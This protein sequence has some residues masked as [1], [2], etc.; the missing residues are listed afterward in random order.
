MLRTPDVTWPLNESQ[1]GIW[2]TQESDPRSPMLN[3]GEYY[4]IPGPV[5]AEVLDRAVGLVVAENDILRMRFLSTESGPRQYPDQEITHPLTVVDVSADTDPKAAALAIMHED[6]AT[7]LDMVE[8]T[9]YAHTLFRLGNDRHIWYQRAHHL[10]VDGYTFM[11]LAR[12]VAEVYTALLGGTDTGRPYGS[13]SALLDEA[14]RYETGEEREEDARYWTDYLAG[15]P[16]HTALTPHREDPRSHYLRSTRLMDEE[17]VSRIERAAQRAGTGW[18]Q[19]L[20]A[21][22]AAYTHRWTGERDILLSL[23]VAARTTDLSRRTPGMSSNVVPLR[24][25]VTPATSLADLAG[26]VAT[27]LRSCLP[28]QRHPAAATR[29]LLGQTPQ[30]R[31]EF[32]PLVNIMSFDYGL[33]FGGVPSV[34]HNIF[35]GP[36]EELRIDVLQRSRG[37]PL[38]IDFDANPAVFSPEELERHADSFLRLLDALCEDPGVPVGDL[39]LLTEEERGRVLEEFSGAAVRSDADRVVHEV[40][41]ER[42]AGSPDAVALVF[43]EERLTYGEVN[44]RAN[45]LARHLRSRGLVTGAAAGVLLERGVEF[46]VALLAVLKAGAA[47]VPLDPSFPDDRLDSMMSAAGVDLVVTREDMSDRRV[48]TRERVRVDTE[49]ETIAGHRSDGLGLRVDPGDVACVMFTSGS[50][51]TPKGVAAPHRAVVSTLLG[52]DYLDFGPEQVWLQA[53]PVSWDA[54]VLEFWGALLHGSV[55]VLH[56]GQV[57]EPSRIADLVARH[58]V[59]TMWLSAGLFNLLLDECPEVFSGVGQVA[60]GGEAPSVE[61]MRRFLEAFPDVRLQHG[62]GPVE[63]MVFTNSHRVTRIEGGT[64]PV[65]APLVNRRC[66]VLDGR[67]RPVPVGVPGELYVGGEGLAL[68]YVGRPDLTAERFVTDPFHGRGERMYRTGDLVRWTSDG[69]LEFLGRVDD[70]VKIRGFRI[71][72]GEVEAALAALP[73]VGQCAVVV[74]EDRP[75]DKRLVAYTAPSNESGATLDAVA[76]RAALATSLPDYMLPSVVVVLDALPLNANGKLDRRALPAPD[77]GAAATG[78]GPRTPQEEILCGVFRELLG[79]DAVGIDDSFFDLGG[80]SLLLSR[81]IGR[82]RALLGVE[83]NVRDLFRSPTVAAIGAMVGA[84]LPGAVRRPPVAV[85]RPRRVPLSFAQRRLWF[86]NRME[87]PSPTYNIPVVL[88]LRGRVEEDALRSALGDVVARHEALRTVFPSEEGEPYQRILDPEESGPVLE[89]EETTTSEVDRLVHEVVRHAFD[90]EARIPFRA[91]LLRTSEEESVLVVLLHHIAGDGWSMG[92]LMDDLAS[93]YT[94]RV[95]NREPEWNGRP[96]LAIQYAD[97]TLWQNGLMD[98]ED[99]E[100]LAARQLDFWREALDG[101]PEVLD[102]P[103]D[104]PRPTV[105]DHRGETV[106][107]T[108]DADLHRSLSEVA[109]G[110]GVTLFMVF[111]AALAVALSRSGAGEDVPIGTPVA[112]RTDPALDDLVGFFVNTLVLRTDVSGDPSFAELLERVREADLA[113]FDHQDVPFDKVVEALAPARSA[114]HHPLFQVMLVLQNNRE[115]TLELPGLDT[116]L[117]LCSTGASKFD[118]T[119]SL[120]EE[121]DA[122]GPA[123]IT[124]DLEFATDLFDRETAR[125][126]VERWERVLA[127]VA[128]DPRVSVGRIDV[129]SRQER[130]RVL[131]ELPGEGERS[132][133][134]DRA[135]HEVFEERVAQSPDAVALVFG[136][137]RLTYGEVNA[138]ANRLARHLRNRGLRRGDVAGVYLPRGPEM[139]VAVLAVL[140]AGAGY[141]LLDVEFPAERLASVVDAAGVEKVISEGEEG[142]V[143]SRAESVRIDEDRALIAALDTADLG[144]EVSAA[145]VACVMFT[146]GSTGTPKGVMAP[147]RALV[148]TFLGQDYADFGADQVWLQCSPVSWDAFA[149]ELFG[150]LL[151]GGRCVLQPGQRPRFDAIADLVVRHGV[152]DLQMSAGLFNVMLDERPEVFDVVRVAMTAGEA[153]SVAHVAKA[154]AEHPGVRVVNGYGPAE[155]MGFTT[156]HEVRAVEEGQ[157][158]IPIGRPIPGGRTYVLDG[159]MRPVPVGVTGELYVGGEG[160]ALGYVGRPDLTAERFV[161]DPFGTPG[162]RMYRTGDLVRWTSDGVLEYLGRADDQV[163]VRGFRVEPGEVEAALA[164]LPGVGR[165][166]VVVREDR[167][168]DKRLVAYTT[169]AHKDGVVLDAV[170]LRAGLATSLPEYMVPSAV[171]VLEELPLTANGKLDRRALP[172]PDFSVVSSGRGPRDAREEILC[173]LFAEVLGLESVGI[174]DSFFD[175]GGHSLLATKLI[176]RIRAVL[177]AE[178][179]LRA[180]FAS[181]TVVGVAEAVDAAGGGRVRPP[182]VAGERPEVLPLSFAQ[183]RLWFLNRLKGA[184]TSYNVPLVLRLRGRVDEDALRSALGDVVARHEVLRTVFPFSGDEPRQ[185]VFTEEEARERPLLDVHTCPRSQTPRRVDALLE[186]AF[187]LTMDL[188]VRADLLRVSEEES[189]LVV[190][191]HHIATDGWSEGVLLRDLAEAYGARCEGRIPGWEPLP[192][193]YTDYTLWQN[194]LMDEEDPQGLAARQLDFWRETLDG[195][196]QALELPTDRPRPAVASNRGESLAFDLDADLHRSLSEVARGHGVTLFMVFQAALAVALSR[197]GAGEDVPIGTPVAGRTDPALDDLVGFFV[198]T[199]VLRTDVSGDPSFAELLERV[200]EADLA[201]FEHADVPFERVVEAVAP[202]RS[203]GHHPLFQVM[204]VLQNNEAADLSLPGLEVERES[205][206]WKVSKFDLTFSLSERAEGVSGLLEFATDL[207]DRET[208]RALVERW[209]R[210]LAAVA[211]D[212]RVSVGR[213]DVLSRRERRRVLEEFGGAAERSDVDGVVHEV[214]E[215]R[216]AQSPDAVALVF[217]EERLTYGE[218]NARANRLAR[219]LREHG[220][221]PGAMVGVY[222]PRGPEMVVAVLAVLKAGA[223]YTLLDV[224]FPAAR[225]ASVIASAGVGVVVSESGSNGTPALSGV[226]TVLVDSEAGCISGHDEGDL[227]LEVSPES[228]ACVM[229]TSGS[230]GT[231]KGVVTAHRGLVG[232]FVDQDYLDFDADQVWLQ[233]SPV[234]WDAFALEL[235]GAL[236]FGGRCVLQPGQRPRFDA[237]ADLVVRHGVTDLQMSAGLFNVMLDE[238][239]EVFD[240][241]RVAMT[242]GEAASVAHV[243]KALAEHPG[244]RVVNGYGPAENMGFTTTHEVGSIDGGERS[245]P[246]GSPVGGSRVYVLDRWLDPVPTGVPGE[247]YIAGCTLAQ[248]YLR[249]P[250]LTAERF[251]PDPFG[252]PGG[253]MYRTGDLVRWTSGGV[254]EYLGRADDQVKVR[255]FR[256]EPGEVEAA[257]MGLAGV[258][259]AVVV[260]RRDPDDVLSLVGY[261]VPEAGVVLD[262]VVLRA[263]LAT[264][265]PEYMVPSAV[266]VL[267]ELPLTAN[268]KLDRRALPEPDFSVVSSGRGPRDAREEILCGLFAEVLGLESVGIDDSF[269]DLGG[270]SLLATKLIAR[271]HSAMDAKM[272]LEDVFRAPTVAFLAERLETT[273]VAVARPALRRRTRAGVEI[274]G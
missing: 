243:A 10:L 190:L 18:K 207:F 254:L 21:A 213:I 195:S 169:P 189:V 130:R 273:P 174:D 100:G 164:A 12:R 145:D 143:T 115:A 175:L 226:H 203:M 251:V 266:V 155:N 73:G 102:L 116:T 11:L 78:R 237:I 67:M 60:T 202:A 185:R 200:R 148:G 46:A 26:D 224:E 172:E 89:V 178:V 52:Q 177:G 194:G 31:R 95:R 168:G 223:G 13:F 17:D 110:H 187:D 269:F 118:L 5:D 179:E 238:R 3:N 240:V 198:N 256:V 225:V 111:Q 117:E 166:A 87:G 258:A 2:F 79:V 272:T 39:D 210:V 37:G 150:A 98:E 167:P 55:C 159:R 47:Y 61:H 229:F 134:A 160:L 9:L 8:D 156:F 81:L 114:A 151:F 30:S 255:G 180:L 43:G 153:A 161:P 252:T 119:L 56:D 91:W 92:P 246:V 16:H 70:Q 149:L 19:L 162:G 138:R 262:A 96:E 152:T 257:L 112:G 108:L 230:S 133:I 221:E 212:P 74:R 260:P 6:L 265:L 176:A 57:P 101:A 201:A 54:F 183:R 121:I 126:L 107:L 14:K 218:V 217:G 97:Y 64:V 236:L 205:F 104:R 51:G 94:D 181:P 253:R 242:A 247:L 220:V 113:A 214:F 80:H 215:E 193:Q 72:P 170:V 191:M 209:E 77:Y 99:P 146:S 124:G 147:H 140:K 199:L 131:E 71:E 234:S 135:V 40:F 233:C 171:V 93:A 216:V 250:D 192:I 122:S 120:S 204:L 184:S 127:A 157:V 76:L 33:D 239:P 270:H 50:T 219:H 20:M 227:G 63:S 25:D 188:P 136:E 69:V 68:G 208:A 106:P 245:V 62:Y 82:V 264:S 154:L 141:T 103:L 182:V 7:P 241:V 22:V 84:A 32:G 261:V 186:R 4:E 165:C 128:A 263:G 211:A 249:R 132:G 65:G 125:A 137:E 15:A 90:I 49:A 53:A 222:L 38:H 36:I 42:A 142:P 28:H 274:G 29:R 139:V 123:G 231:P 34:P 244:V 197:S 105:A 163:K 144:I 129:L 196:P 35:Q 268:G 228:V 88:R 173:G 83:L 27:A 59:T 235:F 45:R 23:P 24:F 41:E 1:S 48:G 248:G 66:Y 259:Q 158:S 58:G 109:R 75:G 271:V 267:E 232:T 85:E 44:A 206:A 86:L